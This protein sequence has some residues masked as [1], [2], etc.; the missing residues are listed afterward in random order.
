MSRNPKTQNLESRLK[1]SAFAEEQELQKTE[2]R[3]PVLSFYPQQCVF[4]LIAKALQQCNNIIL[5]FKGILYY[6]A[7]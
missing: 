4:T 2:A 1:L 5:Y 3:S 6:V 7:L